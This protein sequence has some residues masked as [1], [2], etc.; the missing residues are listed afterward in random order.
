[1][2]DVEAYLFGIEGLGAVHIRDLNDHHFQRP[3]HEIVASLPSVIEFAGMATAMTFLEWLEL[4]GRA[5]RERD[6]ATAD[7]EEID[8][9]FGT[10]IVAGSRA[11]VEWWA[12]P[13]G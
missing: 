8:L 12:D 13:H 1:V 4:Y 3:I 11:A 10:P 5:W 9:R 6:A 7:Q 2:V